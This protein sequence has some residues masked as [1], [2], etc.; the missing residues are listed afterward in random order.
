MLSLGLTL[1]HLLLQNWIEI[2]IGLRIRR[3]RRFYLILLYLWNRF[4]VLYDM[5]NRWSVTLQYTTCRGCRMVFPVF[6]RLLG[7]DKVSY[8]SF[9]LFHIYGHD[10]DLTISF[11]SF[12]LLCVW[13]IALALCDMYDWSGL[14]VYHLPGM[15]DNVSYNCVVRGVDK[16]SYLPFSILISRSWGGRVCFDVSNPCATIIMT[17]HKRESSL[18]Y[19]LHFTIPR[20]KNSNQNLNTASRALILQHL[21]HRL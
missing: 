21:S 1:S 20:L 4:L 11:L 9:L 8:N 6:V 14:A 15:Q 19:P 13:Y 18:E 3:S 5:C 7:L 2:M 16:V 17:R 12:I 10:M